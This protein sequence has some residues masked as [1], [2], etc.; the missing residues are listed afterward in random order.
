VELNTYITHL[1]VSIM[2]QMM[3]NLLS[4][5]PHTFWKPH[6]V[7][8]AVLTTPVACSL[9]PL[10]T[11]GRRTRG[12][13]FNLLLWLFY[14]MNHNSWLFSSVGHLVFFNSTSEKSALPTGLWPG[15]GH[16]ILSLCSG[17]HLTRASRATPPLFAFRL[18]KCTHF[19][20][21]DPIT[22]SSRQLS[23]FC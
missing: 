5:V 11:V 21:P 19:H 18:L 9:M 14:S 13:C 17:E 8:T 15:F 20:F 10:A 16:V 22:L 23:G 3:L 4:K 12:S 7:T 6:I 2:D 1:P